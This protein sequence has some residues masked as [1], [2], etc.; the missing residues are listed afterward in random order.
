MFGLSFV[1]GAA[2]LAL[3]LAGLPILLHMLYRRRS[4]ILLFST[5]RFVKASL[6]QTAAQRRIQR[7]ILLA[8]RVLLLGLLIWAVAQPQKMPRLAAADRGLPTLAAIVVDTGYS[9]LLKED[10]LTLL[11]RANEIVTDL[12]RDPLKDAAGDDLPRRR[13]AG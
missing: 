13:R 2:L 3:P 4:P 12:L 7:W 5:L 6:Q 9:M 8:C 11:D 1:F 10:Q